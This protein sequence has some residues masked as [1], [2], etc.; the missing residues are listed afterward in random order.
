MEKPSEE[1]RRRIIDDYNAQQPNYSYNRVH[2]QAQYGRIP[3]P[4]PRQNP[5]QQP[6]QPSPHQVPAYEPRAQARSRYSFTGPN[7]CSPQP[8][9][10]YEFPQPP[11][12]AAQPPQTQT[13]SVWS[14]TRQ[15]L[16][17]PNPQQGL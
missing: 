14:G 3:G 4:Q 1:S 7:A 16:Y 8:V 2:Y 11:Q 15:A 12:S 9:S 10:R 6:P 13:Q 5:P 17:Y